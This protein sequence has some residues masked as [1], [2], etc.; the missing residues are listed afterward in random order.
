MGVPD[1]QDE[2]TRL[3]TTAVGERGSGETEKL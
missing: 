3:T 1:P 2:Q